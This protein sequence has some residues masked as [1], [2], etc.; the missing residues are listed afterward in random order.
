MGE[1]GEQGG[2]GEGGSLFY[3][4]QV[5]VIIHNQVWY[6]IL[7]QSSCLCRLVNNRGKVIYCFSDMVPMHGDKFERNTST[8]G[9]NYERNILAAQILVWVVGFTAL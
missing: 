4:C 3:I 5:S 1:R 6:I 8:Q 7:F 9:S 2:G